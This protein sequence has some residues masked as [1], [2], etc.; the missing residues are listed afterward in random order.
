MKLVLATRNQGKVREL[1]K[2]VAPLGME[3]V[4]MAEYPHV[5]EVVEDGETFEDNAVKKAKSVASAT[6]LLTLADDSGLEV[7]YLGGAPGVHSA[8]FSGEE[9]DDQANNQK[10]LRLLEGIPR[11]K[12]SAR[13]RC[14]VAIAT[15]EGKVFTASGSCEGVIGTAPKGDGGFGYDPL[16]YVPDFG[17]TFSELDLET[18]NKISHRGRAFALASEILAGLKDETA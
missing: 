13:F 10:L 14:V 16:F 1:A 17:K 12:R 11:E 3:V 7:D 18:K 8:R 5:P 2:L 9:K 4:S 15:P 6:G